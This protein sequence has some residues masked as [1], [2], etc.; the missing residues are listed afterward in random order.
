MNNTI[1]VAL[2][3]DHRLLRNGLSNFI[4]NTPDFEVTFEAD[5]GIDLQE[6]IKGQPLPDVVLMDINMPLMDGYEATQWL[7]QHHPSV[8]VI[9][10]SMYDSEEC[11]IRMLRRGA[12]G[13]LL[14]DTEP[15]ELIKAIIETKINGYYYTPMVAK[16]ISLLI[17][18]TEIEQKNASV[19]TERELELL[20]LMASEFTYKE[21]AD[22][23]CLSPKT[24]ENHREKICEKLQVKTRVGLVMYAMKNGLVK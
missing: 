9:A 14:K 18:D 15:A 21:I 19:L 12:K 5:N 16:Q 1:N 2:V 10:L 24:V 22:K 23:M 13:Y 7:Y 17:N 8:K 11:I 4:K 6:K 20:Q 3:D